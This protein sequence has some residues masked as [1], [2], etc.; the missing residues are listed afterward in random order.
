MHI[1]L[2]TITGIK[3]EDI[4][5]AIIMQIM[6]IAKCASS[7]VKPGFHMIVAIVWIVVNDSS[8]WPSYDS[9]QWRLFSLSG[10]KTAG[11]INV[12]IHDFRQSHGVIFVALTYGTTHLPCHQRWGFISNAYV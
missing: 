8:D 5:P 6:H 2:Q 9:Q 12:D 3:C 4:R 1:D 10:V 7:S 11:I